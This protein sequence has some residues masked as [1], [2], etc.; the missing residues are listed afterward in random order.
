MLRL[1]LLL[2]P[3]VP[4]EGRLHREPYM[5]MCA[6]VR[7]NSANIEPFWC[8]ATE[9]A[10]DE[11]GDSHAPLVSIIQKVAHRFFFGSSGLVMVACIAADR[12][13][14]HTPFVAR[15]QD[16]KNHQP[17]CKQVVRKK[18]KHE[19]GEQA[20]ETKPASAEGAGIDSVD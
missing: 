12:D 17:I 6:H 20:G 8:P 16:W 15:L 7:E 1:P 3:R 19:D 18:K 2:L 14:P 9:L 10:T 13:K 11:K 4:E 5:R